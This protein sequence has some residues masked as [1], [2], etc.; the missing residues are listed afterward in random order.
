MTWWTL[1]QAIDLMTPILKW[2]TIWEGDSIWLSLVAQGFHDI[3]LQ[4]QSFVNRA[5]SILNANE[6]Q[7]LKQISD[8][9]WL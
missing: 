2:I 1:E 7:E 4:L 8:A 3:G 6:A 9:I 5:P